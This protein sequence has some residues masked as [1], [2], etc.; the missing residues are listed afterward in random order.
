M[1]LVLLLTVILGRFKN[2]HEMELAQPAAG[3]TR[4]FSSGKIIKPWTLF[5]SVSVQDGS[6]ALCSVKNSRNANEVI[7]D[8]KNINYFFC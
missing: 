6:I 3:K 1:N 7:P 5:S 2:I 8:K 4:T